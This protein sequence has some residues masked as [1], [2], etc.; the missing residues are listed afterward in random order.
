MTDLSAV[1][2][3]VRNHAPMLTRKLDMGDLGEVQAEIYYDAGIGT[4]ACYDTPETAGWFHI[5][6]IMVNGFDIS[7]AF[8]KETIDNLADFIQSEVK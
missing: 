6:A 5:T 1:R 4:R 2:E 7:P 3:A 8:S